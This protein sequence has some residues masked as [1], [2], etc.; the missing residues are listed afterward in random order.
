MKK[1]CF[2]WEQVFAHIWRHCDPDGIWDGSAERL[3]EK[4][5]VNED[6]AQAM[7]DQLCDR[8]LLER[9]YEATYAITKWHERDD[10]G[11]GEL[12]WEEISALPE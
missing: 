6:A 12:R 7:L 3:A 2:D 11:V 4:F 9:V 1:R 5:G 10:P 8:G